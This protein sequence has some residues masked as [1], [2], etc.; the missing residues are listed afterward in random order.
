MYTFTSADLS[1]WLNPPRYLSVAALKSLNRL[2]KEGE[3]FLPLEDDVTPHPTLAL[4]RRI[5]ADA[6]VSRKKNIKFEGC[7]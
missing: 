2:N 7:N 6:Q 5:L 3:V 1:L 4:M